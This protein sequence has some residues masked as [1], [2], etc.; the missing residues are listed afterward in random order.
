MKKTY[1]IIILLLIAASLQSQVRVN[2]S[3]QNPRL[4]QG[5]FVFDVTATIPAGQ[6]W[7]VGPTCIR[8][9][10]NTIPP[11]ALTVLEDMPA[12]NANLN[13]SNN[14]NYGNMTT[15]SI[16]NDTAVS[17]NILQLYQRNCYALTTGTHALGSVRWN[18]VNQNA[19]INITFQQISVIMDSLTG[20]TFGP[21]WTATNRGCDPIGIVQIIDKTPTSYCLYQNYPNPF[22][23]GTKIRY[24][25]PKTTG[26][27]LVIYDAL[28]RVV[29]TLVDMEFGAG[30]YEVTWDGSS[31]SSGLYFYKIIAGDYVHTNKMVLIK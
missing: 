18:V 28:G 23:P 31:Y 26:V 6:Q 24:D 22:N 20:L 13:L 2:F 27:K 29:E 25:I 19:C 4:D 11:G 9:S 7:K 21:Q 30:S 17:L 15:T 12:A 3:L 14:T 10:F 16:M 8:V 5:K 1:I